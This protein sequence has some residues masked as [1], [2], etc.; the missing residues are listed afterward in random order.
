VSSS[1]GSLAR[2]VRT[3]RVSSVELV[4]AALERI[5]ADRLNAVVAIRADEALAD[6]RRVDRAVRAGRRL[7]PLAGLPALIKDTEDVAG[8]RTTHGSL[9]HAEDSPAGADGLVTR[10]LRAAGA[11]VV[12]KTNAPEFAFEG[13]TANRVFGATGNPWRP[14]WSPGGSSGGSGAALAAALAPIATA[15]DGGGSIRIPAALCGLAGLKPTAGVVGR[16]PIPDW[17]DLTT[18]GP[19]ATSVADVALLL[20]VL[21]GPTPG[22]PTA[23][24]RWR[25]GP[26]TMPRRA[27]ALASFDSGVR[28]G[29][30]VAAMFDAALRAVEGDLRMRVKRL[31]SRDVIAS[32]YQ[33]ADWFRI[34]GPE[35]LHALGEDRLTRHADRLDPV[36]RRAME[37]AATIPARDHIEAR[38]RRFAYSR[39]IDDL[40]GDDAVLLTP[41]LT[42]EGWFADGRLP[43]RDRPGL[44][45]EVFNTE[46]ANLTGHPALSL[47]AGRYASGVP[48]GLQVIGP[49]YREALLI[50]FGRA[51]ERARPWPEVADGFT[52]FAAR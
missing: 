43:D 27:F 15:G 37:L 33:T 21:A 31:E 11:V 6:A 5:A 39:A 24:D 28:L 20:R 46:L 18:A 35:Q 47:P 25:L 23:Q 14:E 41:T 40:L 48:F 52:P 10:R 12:G 34:A 45:S 32:G 42:V 51:W 2:A 7:G 16:E 8:M 3:R 19:L 50:G 49:R 44:P 29:R 4:R 30:P 9:L 38:R 17:I 36:F 22:D 1:L 26:T 13:Y